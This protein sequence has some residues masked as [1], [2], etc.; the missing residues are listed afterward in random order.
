MYKSNLY[1]HQILFLSV[2]FI[3]CYR[4]SIASNIRISW[5]LFYLKSTTIIVTMVSNHFVVVIYVSTT[6]CIS[7]NSND[8]SNKNASTI[9]PHFIA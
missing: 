6:S 3:D 7:A 2:F 9:L 5:A 4:V 1:E 8:S